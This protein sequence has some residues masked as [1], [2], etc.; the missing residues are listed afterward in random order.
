M[1]TERLIDFLKQAFDA[2]FLKNARIIE[3]RPAFYC[4]TTRLLRDLPSWYVRPVRK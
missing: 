3:Q 2:T 4:R 1:E